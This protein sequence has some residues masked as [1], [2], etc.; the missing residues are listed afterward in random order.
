MGV[1]YFFRGP[2]QAVNRWAQPC[3]LYNSF[4]RG[5]SIIEITYIKCVG[6]PYKAAC[7]WRICSNGSYPTSLGLARRPGDFVC[8][9]G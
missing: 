5:S 2:L 4:L 1:V 7:S 8:D 3:Y 6:V 9:L